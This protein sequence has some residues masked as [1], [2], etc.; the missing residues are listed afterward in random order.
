MTGSRP[1]AVCKGF[2][3]IGLIAE[4]DAEGPRRLHRRPPRVDRGEVE[5]R[6]GDRHAL[7]IRR[8]VADRLTEPALVDEPHG[9]GAKLGGQHPIEGGGCA[10]ALEMTEH[11]GADVAAQPRRHLAGHDLADPPKPHL[12]LPVWLIGVVDGST[13]G[14][15]RPL[16]GH[17]EREPLALRLPL[18]NLAADTLERQRNF[19]Q[20]DDVAAAGDARVEGDPA[21]MAAH[22]L[23]N[24][25]PL[26]AG[27]GGVES[28][29]RIGGRGHG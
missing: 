24:H 20:E 6:L 22:H 19:G 23:E 14:Q 2:A 25:H 13:A 16:G 1:P 26:V 10:S 12:P 15:H 11:D 9:M 5:D 17:H 27:A 29:E 8:P 7:D 3:A 18:E 4:P 21:G 28:V